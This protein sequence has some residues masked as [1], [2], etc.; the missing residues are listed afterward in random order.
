MLPRRPARGALAA[1]LALG[2][3]LG[4]PP[5]PAAAVDAAEVRA[6]LDL[7]DASPALRGA[8]QALL[9][10]QSSLPAARRTL[11][12]ARHRSRS[13]AAEHRRAQQRLGVEVTR[14]LTVDA[15]LERALLRRDAVRRE[16]ARSVRDLYVFG[17]APALALTVTAPPHDQA[18]WRRALR[19][20]AAARQDQL[21]AAGRADADTAQHLGG[22]A[23]AAAAA[24]RAAD[25]AAALQADLADAEQVAARAVRALEA[26]E[27]RRIEA[28]TVAQAERAADEERY[29]L[30]QAESQRLAALTAGDAEVGGADPPALTDDD[31]AWHW[32]TAGRI[33]SRFGWRTHP[34]YGTRRMHQGLDVAAP[35]G[36]PVGAVRAGIVVSAGPAGG[37]GLLVVVDHGRDATGRR[38]TSAY[39]HLS[40]LSVQA[41]Q[42]VAAGSVVGLV[43]STGASTGNHLHLEVRLDGTAVDPLVRLRRSSASGA[44][45]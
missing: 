43:G 1:A 45:P 32:P 31:D 30:L 22:L 5:A 42:Q 19:S 8:A 27:R 3:V 18:V 16:V 26:L 7:P 29:R 17:S 10:L 40:S 15:A 25:A 2:A 44:L 39:A 20:R 24:T 33:S 14:R 28:L 35:E 37:Y 12:L 4:V 23:V 41:G 21:A 6:V 36:Q 13:A 9:G 38:V 34:V 11:E